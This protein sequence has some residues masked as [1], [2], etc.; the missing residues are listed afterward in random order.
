MGKFDRSI[1]IEC[2]D[3][4][5]CADRVDGL[6]RKFDREEYLGYIYGILPHAARRCKLNE[7]T[8]LIRDMYDRLIIFEA[9]TIGRPI[10]AQTKIVNI[11]FNFPGTEQNDGEDT[12][13]KRITFNASSL[14]DLKPVIHA[15]P[16]VELWE[17]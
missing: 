17:L 7:S 2:S 10:S 4:Q 16:K 12:G 3:L 13:P 1:I 15:I 5:V 9:F 11:Y 8:L 14:Q 6:S